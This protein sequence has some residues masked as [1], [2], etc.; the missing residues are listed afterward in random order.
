MNAQLPS[1][2]PLLDVLAAGFGGPGMV[3]VDNEH[4]TIHNPLEVT[5]K[6]ATPVLL[7][8]LGPAMLRLAGER[9]DGTILWL[10]DEK[11]IGE[12]IAPRIVCRGADRGTRGAPCRSRRFQCVYVPITRL[13]RRR[14]GPTGSCPK[15]KSLPTTS[16]SSIA[17]M[18]LRS[19]TF[20]PLVMKPL[21]SAACNLSRTRVRPTCRSGWFRSA[22]DETNYWHQAAVP[23]TF[24]RTW[25]PRFCDGPGCALNYR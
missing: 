5:D 3:D 11:S 9:T 21:C 4:Y 1:S 22:T 17:A 25:H 20:W 24:S 14:S 19:P 12:Y 8:A 13:M 16:V 10:A 2:D 23:E 6:T 7:A 15:L 18:R